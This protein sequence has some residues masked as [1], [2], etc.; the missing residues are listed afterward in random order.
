M[1]KKDQARTKDDAFK[2]GPVLGRDAILAIDDLKIEDVLTPEWGG[3]VFVRGMTGAA[4]D[5][6][7]AGIIAGV[8]YSNKDMHARLATFTVCDDTG[9]LL[10][11]PGDPEDIKLLT[12]K[13]AAP[14][15]RIFLVA[16]RLSGMHVEIDEL[17]TV[18]KNARPA[19]SPTA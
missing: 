9:K 7:E 17:M 11:R 12:E 15:H 14:L 2:S 3:H 19:S 18:L 1:S 13:S 8:R 10:F 4:R 5:Q 6:Y 16:Q